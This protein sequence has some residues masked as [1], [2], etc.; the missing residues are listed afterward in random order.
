MLYT[1]K[2]I[3]CLITAPLITGSLLVKPETC[4]V[5]FTSVAYAEV[6]MYIGTAEGYA[7]TLESQEVAKLRA[8]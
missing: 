8:K 5:F 6:K 2:K 1:G 3:R 4:G 7:S